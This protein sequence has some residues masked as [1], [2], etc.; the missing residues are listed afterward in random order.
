MSGATNNI[1]QYCHNDTNVAKK[2]HDTDAG[3]L[4]VKHI[5]LA[6]IM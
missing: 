6:N 1:L 5:I 4:T 3:R 2:T